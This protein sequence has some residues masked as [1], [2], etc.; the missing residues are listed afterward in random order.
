M[1]ERW[2]RR[3]EG[4]GKRCCEEDIGEQDGRQRWKMRRNVCEKKE[5]KSQRNETKMKQRN[6]TKR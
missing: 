2:E 4:D 5:E 6:E 1:L 3:R